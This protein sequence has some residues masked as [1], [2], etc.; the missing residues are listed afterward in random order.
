[1]DERD[2]A[3]GTIAG[4]RGRASRRSGQESTYLELNVLDV[5]RDVM[6]TFSVP[7]RKSATGPSRPSA[8]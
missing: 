8:A 3:F 5:D 7:R 4:A 1:M 6:Q 2:A